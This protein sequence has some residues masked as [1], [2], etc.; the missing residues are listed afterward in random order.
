MNNK[1]F[2]L[3]EL[4]VVILL[5]GALVIIVFPSINS[6]FKKKESDINGAT[7]DII[8]SSVD[9]YIKKHYEDYSGISGTT[10]CIKISDVYNEN[11]IPIDIDDY[12]DKTVEIKIG[13]KNT[14]E[15]KECE[16][17]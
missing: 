12:I 2:T 14:Y 1:A 17:E 15:I 8:Y 11:L 10:Y 13:T 7:K 9:Q 16:S 3:A 4:L 6:L 5:L